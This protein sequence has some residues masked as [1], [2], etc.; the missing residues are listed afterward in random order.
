MA[1]DRAPPPVPPDVNPRRDLIGIFVRHPTAANLLMVAMILVGVF[2]LM[3]MNTQFF[4]EF[5]I[6]IVTV[7][8]SWPGASAEDV[9]ANIV[10]AIEPEVRFLD[11]V[12][13]VRSTSSEG[14]ALIVIEYQSGA[15]MQLA[16]SNVETAVGQVTTL[17]E[18]SERPVVRRIVNYEPIS[19]I[20]I[21]GPYS[22]SA[23]KAVAKRMREIN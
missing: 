23:L 15:D 17:P 13:R 4:P 18:D 3:R 6:D 8:V 22:E 10:E 5:G 11:A 20:L 16:L 7:E 19:S 2:S 21:S 14:A 9:D 1:D 12:K